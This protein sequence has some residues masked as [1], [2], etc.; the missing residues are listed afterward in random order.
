MDA[1]T[2]RTWEIVNRAAR[3]SVA[4]ETTLLA[5]GVPAGEGAAL[6]RE[7]GEI[8]RA[9]GAFPCLIGMVGGRAIAGLTEE[10]L[11]GL[12]EAPDL[13]KTNSANL[14]ALA[15]RGA[16]AATSVSTTME[17]A[18][19]VGVRVFA[20][21]GIGGVHRGYARRLD[22]SADLAALARWPVAVVCSG[23]KSILAVESTREALETL[24][25]PVAGFRTDAFPAFYHRE[26]EAGV[27]ARFDDIDELGAF[28]DFEIGRTS[29]GVVVCNPI[30]EADEIDRTAFQRWLTEA[31]ETIDTGQGRAVTPALLGRL[32]DLSNGATLRANLALVRSNAQLAAQLAT[33][34]EAAR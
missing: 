10:E 1:S 3:R 18:A 9:E 20:T 31:E 28:I 26:S 24:G 23:V 29:R 14:G 22:V 33:K 6:A 5:H 34:L 15:F 17:I 25:V 16:D 19:G 8:I 12:L 4:L 21:G 13:P 30:P 32:H 7:L 27:D 2:S 11:A